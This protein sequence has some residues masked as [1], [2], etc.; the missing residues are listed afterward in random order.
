M[1]MIFRGNWQHGVRP[2]FGVGLFCA[3]GYY[4]SARKGV[5]EGQPLDLALYLF[6]PWLVIILLYAL[7]LL[8]R[9]RDRDRSSRAR[10]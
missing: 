9:E 1:P 6:V 3:V 8:R 2:G 10:Q 5:T 7:G 4:L